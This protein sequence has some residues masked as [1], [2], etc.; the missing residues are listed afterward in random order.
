MISS[1]E[2]RLRTNQNIEVL[3]IEELN[4]IEGMIEDAI[5]KGKYSINIPKELFEDT[6]ATLTEELYDITC[7]GLSTTISWA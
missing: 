2:A 6:I 4:I 5:D 1:N 7:H 3:V